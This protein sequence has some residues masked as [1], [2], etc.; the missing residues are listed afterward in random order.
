MLRSVLCDSRTLACRRW[1]PPDVPWQAMPFREGSPPPGR[2]AH[3][4]LRIVR[5]RAS[6][7]L[8]HGYERPRSHRGIILRRSAFGPLPR[9]AASA[10]GVPQNVSSPGPSAGERLPPGAALRGRRRSRQF[11]PEPE[12]G[13]PSGRYRLRHRA[14]VGS[15]R[16]GPS[17]RQRRESGLVAAK[18]ARPRRSR[19]GSIPRHRRIAG[20]GARR[21]PRRSVCRLPQRGLPDPIGHRL[22]RRCLC[23][24]DRD[25]ERRSYWTATR[26]PGRPIPSPPAPQTPSARGGVG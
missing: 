6:G 26:R 16:S 25:D 15:I 23:L 9:A 2:S 21:E 24:T 14:L 10:R 19:V 13:R 22:V 1:L 4:L 17:V 7:D 20:R 18:A 12:P 11:R 5:W 8:R 3:G